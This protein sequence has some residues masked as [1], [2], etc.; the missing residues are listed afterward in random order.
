M[1]EAPISTIAVLA[2]GI[3]TRMR[4]LTE[5]VPKALL[6]VAGEPFIAH[7]LRLFRREGITRVILCVGYLGQQIAEFVG[8][9]SHFGL[10]VTYSFDGEP[11]LGTGGALR[12]AL[13][14]LGERFY[15]IYGDS[16]L[17]VP[18]APAAMHY[19]QS[20]K[21]GLMTVFRNE[22]RWDTSNVAFENGTILAYSKTSKRSGMLYIDYGLGILKASTLLAY[23]E[24]DA[25]DLAIVYGALIARGQLA[26]YEALHRFYE[27]GSPAGLAETSAYIASK[28]RG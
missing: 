22:G 15:V 21:D 6:E 20:G 26:G 10:A 9:G 14:H 7:Q 19:L 24:H 1:S 11:L 5:T 27:I 2:G 8:D 12:K 4:P 18:Y 17:D 13:P 25:F 16:Y 23:G 28:D 3:A